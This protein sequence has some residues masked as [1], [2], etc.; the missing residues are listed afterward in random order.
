ML[1]GNEL[2]LKWVNLTGGNLLNLEEAGSCTTTPPQDA[3]G[4]GFGGAV[5]AED[6]K[7]FIEFCA[8]YGN[9]AFGGGAIATKNAQSFSLTST[10][11]TSNVG[12]QYGGAVYVYFEQANPKTI[13]FDRLNF[14][15][16]SFE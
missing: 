8:F 16:N 13:N 9:R 3:P 2:V 11:F 1:N 10:S 5:Y 14:S 7:L 4:C 15:N 6:S 12:G